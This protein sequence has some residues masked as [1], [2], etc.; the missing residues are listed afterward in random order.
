MDE[1]R[2]KGAG[3]STRTA[4]ITCGRPSSSSR[5]VWRYTPWICAAAVIP[6]Y[7]LGHGAGGVVA[8]VYTLEHRTELAGL[9]CESFAHEVPAPGFVVA[10]F[11]GF[12]HIAPHAHILHP[13]NEDFSRDA[14]V[15]QAMNAARSS[16]ARLD[17]RG[18]SPRW[19]ARRAAQ[20]GGHFHDLLN[21]VDKEVVMADIKA[22]I[23]DRLP[24]TASR[25]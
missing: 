1:E 17:P 3:V 22:W 16:P 25:R 15:V 23:D 18:R 14:K 2:V 10:V 8:C 11:K 20:K 7:L 4:V 24:A 19:F 9:I 6:D 12:S 21:D 13:K 5:A